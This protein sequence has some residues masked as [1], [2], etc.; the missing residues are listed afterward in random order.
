MKL[1]PLFEP[2]DR[3]FVLAD[4]PEEYEVGVFTADQLRAYGLACAEAMREECASI[5]ESYYDTPMSVATKVRSIE[6]ER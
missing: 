5:V 4:E 3:I 6:V 1:P 2:F